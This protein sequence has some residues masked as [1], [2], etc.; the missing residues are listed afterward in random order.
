MSISRRTFLQTAAAAGVATHTALASS[1]DPKTGMPLRV[2]GKTG[3]KVSILGFG[4]GSRFLMYKEVDQGLAALNRAIDSGINYIDS[5]FNYGNGE[6]ERRIGMVM[7]TRRKDVWLVTKIQD[8]GYDDIMRVFEGSL[9]RLQTDHVDLLHMHG[10]T[11]ADDLAAIEAPTGALKAYHKIRDEK[12]A[13]FIGVTSHTDPAVLKTLLERHDL[14]CVQMALNAAR[15]GGSAPSNERGLEDS[16][17]NIALPVALGKNMGVTAMKVFAQEKLLGDAPPEQLVRYAM[18]L[19]VASA[20]IG[21]PK[22]ELLDAN[23]QTAKSF[24]PMPEPEMKQLSDR[25]SRAKKA[26]LDRYF[27]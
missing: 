13:R 14:D 15:I 8:R 9:K 24:Q 6:S 27:L 12:M 17:D 25:I 22:L 7:K 21:M 11:G 23:I 4:S 19:P 5:A 18:S 20:V 3:A 10:L 26:S 1:I 2:L 16:F